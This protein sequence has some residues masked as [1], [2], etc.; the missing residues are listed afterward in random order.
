MRRAI[1]LPL[2]F[3]FGIGAPLTGVTDTQP[4]HLPASRV[5]EIEVPAPSL[6]ANLLGTPAMQGAAVYLPPGY[7]R[8]PA[9]RFPVV[10]LLHGIFD[11]YRVF[12]GHFGVPTMADRLIA[13]GEV[14]EMIIVMPNGGNQ[15][16]GG[17]YRNSPVSGAWGDFITQDLVGFIDAN[18][19][20]LAER[21]S[22]AVVGHSMGGYGVLHLT[23]T[24][25][26]VFAVAWAMSPCCLTAVDDF[27]FGNNAWKRTATV[28]SQADVDAL[29][30]AGEFYAVA[31][32]GVATAF[33]P[34]PDN[35]PLFID[36]PYEIVRGEIV[37]DQDEHDR[38]LDSLPVNQIEESREALRSLAGL[39]LGVG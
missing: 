37:L 27:G 30:E 33:M 36:L 22:R 20:T 28:Q 34:A 23:M 26:E 15:F 17:F 12:T 24:R 9:R 6:E 31:T 10:Y 38:Y 16:G 18:Y 13:A 39:G 29:L 5:V 19:R 35:P 1:A 21:E 8:E 11:N 7:D 14:P 4:A 2:F 32:L 3:L 25:P